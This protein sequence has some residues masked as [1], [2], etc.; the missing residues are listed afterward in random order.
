[1]SFGVNRVISRALRLIR[2]E[3]GFQ[4]ENDVAREFALDALND[5]IALINKPG[6]L[7]PFHS[8][9]TV[10][11]T[12]GQH[13][14]T[15]GDAAGVDFPTTP[16]ESIDFVNLVINDYHY[17]VKIQDDFNLLSNITTP[18]IEGRPLWVRIIPH[19][20]LSELLF[21]PTPERIYECRLYGK[22]AIHYVNYGDMIQL[23]RA[24]RKYFVYQLAKD[25]NE[26]EGLGTWNASHERTLKELTNQL[27]ASTQKD[28]R[29]RSQPP[30][31]HY[32]VY[33]T[34]NLGVV[35]NGP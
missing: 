30:I 16:F 14:Y 28:N 23:P 1:M 6:Q 13:R 17:Y 33:W 24:Y 10:H 32:D 20:D 12:A 11:L 21:Y 8:E 19:Q 3:A 22:Q 35:N 15:V 27:R 2:A 34:Y 25:L 18:H 31:H 4:D 29:V 9:I 26:Q 5:L 7:I